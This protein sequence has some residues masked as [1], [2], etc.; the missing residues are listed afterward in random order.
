[1]ST[2]E[3]TIIPLISPELKLSDFKEDTGFVGAYVEDVD[4]PFLDNHV[5]LL[6]KWDDNIKNRTL[7]FYKFRELNS[8]Y[9]YRII[10]INGKCMIVY[11]FISNRD[12]NHLKRG[13]NI[14]GDVSKQ[15]ILQFWQFTDSWIT[16]NV[17]RGTV[18]STPTSPLPLEDYMPDAGE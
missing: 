8:F 16:L 9:S 7:I 13:G 6:Y 1:M 14:I 17:T 15:R 12:I 10:Y 18:A 4:R 11:T 3:K 5:F 2:F